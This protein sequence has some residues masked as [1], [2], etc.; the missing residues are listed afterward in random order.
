[1]EPV[2]EIP[3][4]LCSR[5]RFL[6]SDIDD[7]MT[8]EGLLPASSMTAMWRLHEAGVKVIPVTGRP[9]G[10]CD[11]IARM[12]PV[13]AV[14]GENGAFY[15]S[16]DRAARRMHRIYV[17]P[18]EDRRAGEALLERARERILSE[19]PE[20]AIAADQPFRLYDLA[21]DFAEDVG[22][23]SD[24]QID[25]ICAVL[26]DVGLHYKISSIHVNA[27]AGDYDKVGCM[28]MLLDRETRGDAAS[29]P[30]R[31]GTEAA[32]ADSIFIGDSP[33]DEPAFA[34]FPSSVGVANVRDFLSRMKTPPAYVTDARGARGFA[35]AVDTILARR[36]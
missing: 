25:R 29:E 12:W 8:D 10:W 4:G 35:E 24:E 9:A 21:V 14:V 26:D 19:V 22:P 7:T 28:K 15:F 11:H 18:E 16:Y 33:N 32:L 2:S 34:A 5:L 1:M 31:G 23:L 20:A 17:L 30:D 3:P 27:W 6:F 13:E 36:R